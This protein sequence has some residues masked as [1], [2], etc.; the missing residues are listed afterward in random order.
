MKLT[1]KSCY[2]STNRS[3][4]WEKQKSRYI[5]IRRSWERE[6]CK[7]KRLRSFWLTFL[8]SLTVTSHRHHWLTSSSRCKWT[9]HLKS[10]NSR[11]FHKSKTC[12]NRTNWSIQIKISMTCLAQKQ[13][14][15][16]RSTS[17][18]ITSIKT[19]RWSYQSSWLRIKKSSNDPKVHK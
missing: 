18:K 9:R 19:I 16:M 17:V 8:V 3:W 6:P 14:N 15:R 13:H 12:F 4:S 10:N 1:R 11:L 7:G 5:R 2:R